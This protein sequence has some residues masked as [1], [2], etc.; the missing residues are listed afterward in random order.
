MTQKIN[1][2]KEDFFDNFRYFKASRKCRF[3]NNEK[4]W[5]FVSN[6]KACIRKLKGHEV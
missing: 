5:D 4:P 1:L 2:R 3:Q 6:A